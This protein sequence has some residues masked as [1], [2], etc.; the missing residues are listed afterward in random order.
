[1]KKLSLFLIIQLLIVRS[2]FPQVSIN[3]DQT[4]PDPAAMLDVKSTSKGL[5]LPRMNTAQMQGIISPSTGLM[6][7]NTTVH[8]LYWF[9]GSEWKKFTASVHE[10]TDPVFTSYSANGITGIGVSRWDTLYQWGDHAVAGYLTAYMETDPVFTSF[11]A[12]TITG[13]D[14]VN[15]NYAYAD[16]INTAT[17]TQPL[18]LNIS[19]NL[20]SGSIRQAGPVTSGYLTTT[21]WNTFNNKQNTVIAGDITSTDLLIAGG[22]GAI[23]GG[24]VT[25]SLNKG[26]LTSN[27]I[28]I[29]GGTGALIGPGAKLTITK[30]DLTEYSSS[31]FTISNGTGAVTGT[32]TTIG[33]KQASGTQSGY[34]SASDWNVFNN[35]QGALTFGN[36]TSPDIIIT[37]G[38][39][40]VLGSGVNLTID[41]GNLTATDISVSG[42]TDAVAGN[43]TS[44]ALIKGNLTESASS[45]LSITNGTGVLPG[46]GATIQVMEAGNAQAG[47][48][49]SA[50][51]NSFND[52]I[53]SQWITNGTQI[54]YGSG[55][56][57]IGTTSP[58]SSAILD[59]SSTVSGFLPP[60]MTMAQRDA[61]VDPATGL[62]IFCTDC[63]APFNT[64]IFTGETWNPIAY[65][66]Y[67]V[68][69][70]V[71]QSGSPYL[72][73]TLTGSYTYFDADN[74]PE[75]TTTYQWYRADN[76][77]GLNEMLISGATNL[78]YVISGADTLKFVRFSVTPRA[79]T[80]ASPGDKVFA[81]G[82][83]GPVS[84][85]ACGNTYVYIT[86][87]V[88]G[89]VAPVNKAVTYPSASNVPG[90]M[91]KC[92][93]TR[94][95]GAAQ[96][97]TAVND[98][99]EASAGWYWQFNRK[100]GYLHN[101]TTLTPAWTI[102]SINENSD[103]VVANDP[104]SIELMSPWRVPT[105]SE[106]F[107][108]DNTG[109]WTTWDGPWGTNLKIHA[110]GMLNSSG[111]LLYRGS[112][113]YYW[114]STQISTTN[115]R[116]LLMGSA[117]CNLS[118]G[119]KAMGI[120]VR[121]IRDH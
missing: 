23:A 118:N 115:G 100:Q 25:L 75:G 63:A 121:C 54:Y 117:S 62:M 60:R 29:T 102:T 50:D 69:N 22:T 76:A 15:W 2:A 83:V 9:N 64:Q 31:V 45:V 66:R 11:P 88:T 24:G 48:L 94:N 12:Y 53:S 81:A 19:D 5:L 97:A 101:G 109:G 119:S 47:Y 32:G 14:I 4:P 7:Y 99:T 113:G 21:H 34:L 46:P 35:K 65:N 56:V 107:N 42:G 110:A 91:N 51:W 30:G 85:F 93:I 74:D 82:Y 6:V 61:V 68:A 87:L 105:Y 80:G 103:W 38:S 72:Q 108:V 71:S 17:G 92:W 1:M 13:N 10:E 120:P 106:W 67:P 79:Y 116:L 70:A 98:N 37:G 77:S 114:S 111:A 39:G 89:G 73:T 59:V 26:N 78:T 90:E 49:S 16:R 18:T 96:Q 41:K 86:H 40:A 20:L 8:G 44:L 28:N 27:D 57:G 112:S 95:L 33:M 84:P 58:E 52:K 36:L 3:S 55:N 43:G 104:C